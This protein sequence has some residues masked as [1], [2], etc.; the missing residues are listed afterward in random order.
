M[1]LNEFNEM[2]YQPRHEELKRVAD[3]TL[4]ILE[5]N[6]SEGL[7]DKVRRHDRLL[8]RC[9]WVFGIIFIAIVGA[10]VKA[11]MT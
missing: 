3:K 5:G 4:K 7:V 6:G 9:C 1:D 2:I 10:I 8:N 11:F